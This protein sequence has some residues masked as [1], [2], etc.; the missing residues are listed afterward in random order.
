MNTY[1]KKELYQLIKE[2][3]TLF[4]FIQN[5]SLDG[6]SIWDLE[7]SQHE[8]FNPK[9]WT[10]LG[11]DI[12]NPDELQRKQNIIHYKDVLLATDLFIKHFEESNK[13]YEVV[14]RFIHK[15]GNI[16]FMRC[17]GLAI[18]N[19]A[20][21]ITKLLAAYTNVTEQYNF[22]PKIIEL[23]PLH[24][25][26]LNN[27][28]LFIIRTDMT[29]LYTYANEH[30][31]T[32]F[33]FDYD[34]L[35][36][37]NCMDTIY[38]A[39]HQICYEAVIKCVEQIGKSV[40]VKLRK[41]LAN[42]NL[43][44]TQWDFLCVA[45][46]EGNPFEIQCIGYEMEKEIRREKELQ[47]LK[48]ESE[49]FFNL[50]LDLLCIADTE[51]NFIKV[52]KVWEDLLGYSKE[53]LEKKKFTE[54]IH[55][56]DLAATY[57]AIATLSQQ[58]PLL[59][60][61]NRYRCQDGTYKFLEWT[62]QPD[63]NL[64]YAVAR[65]ITEQKNIE[66]KLK[67]SELRLNKAQGIAKIGSW[68]FDLISFNLTWSTEHYH[69]FELENMPADQLY[70]A[71]RSKIHLDDIPTLDSVVQ[72]AIDRGEGFI[73]EHRVLSND[74]SIKY[75]LGIGEVVKDEHGKT[76][77]LVGTVQDITEAKKIEIELLNTKQ[78]LEQTSEVAQIGGWELG[79]ATQKIYWSPITKKIH[80]VA[81]DFEPS[82]VQEG[83]DFYQGEYKELITNL[84][85][86]IIQTGVSFDSELK[87]VTAKANEI[88]V[89]VIGQAEME[90]G[91]CKRIYGT[92]QNI[93]KQKK[94]QIALQRAKKQAEIASFAKSDFLANMS[95]EIRTPLNGVIG[96]TD[97]LMKTKLEESQMQY[98][99]I[100]FQSANS[101]LDVV[102]DILDF[103]K[104][105]AGKLELSI[106]KSDLLLITSQVAD[107]V[108]FQA[109]KKDLEM[110]LNIATNIPRFIIAD[111]VRLRQI[112]VNLLSNA[113]KFTNDGEIELK[114]ELLQMLDNQ[115][116]LRFSIRDTGIGIEEKNRHKIFEA[117]IQEDI[118][119]TRK[120]G[121]TGLGLTISNKLLALMNSKLELISN[122]GKG[123]TFYFD[124]IFESMYGELVETQLEI[125]S[126]LIVDDN[127]NNRRIVKEMLALK[128]IS[129][130][131]ASNGIDAIEMIKNNNQYDVILMD[132]QMPYLDGLDTIRNI[133]RKLALSPE[134]Q[135][136]FLLYSS[137]DDEHIKSA[138]IE[139]GVAQKLVKPIHIQQLYNALALLNK[140]NK[141]T[142]KDKYFANL[143]TEQFQSAAI[144]TI[145]LVEDIAIN[146][147]LA[148]TIIKAVLPNVILIEAK[149]G[150]EA[151]EKYP[152]QHIDFIFMDIQM[153]EKNGYEATMEIREIEKT[154]GKD[155]QTTQT[156]IVAMTAG[157]VK[158]EKEKCLAIGMNDYLSK[159]IVKSS[160]ADILKQYLFDQKTKQVKQEITQKIP[161]HF[162]LEELKQTL[163]ND[164][165][166][167]NE[168]LGMSVPFF[169]TVIVE[170]RQ[171]ID[172]QDV[173]N[174]KRIAHKIKGT[175]LSC[176]FEILANL[177]IEIESYDNFANNK[178]E[179]LYE[180][181]RLEMELLQ[182][183][184]ISKNTSN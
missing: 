1:L 34:N 85:A 107:M 74:G 124:V 88:W 150:K 142:K 40:F 183:L 105:E 173:K 174:I 161:K 182:D 109:N 100:V 81:Q 27:Q 153:P 163:N 134:Q 5:I 129:S 181:I 135:P 41:P 22:Q 125:K 127:A 175:A 176:C 79:V 65:D 137:S 139:L 15:K 64:L 32:N 121:G 158:G 72:N 50:N 66:E 168:M 78:K 156:T 131:Q 69:I 92:F 46:N 38:E 16:I 160:V 91:V 33:G 68:E 55:P 73:Y 104:I 165:A 19:T 9:F 80:E 26:I 162:D 2:D 106:E 111:A 56:E 179:E 54:F 122:V 44:H 169:K 180:L 14:I 141:E 30:F 144:F 101:L 17:H 120:F 84:I 37:I 103:S 4:D 45:D 116:T 113:I 97:L 115:A 61:I 89:R 177:C 112:I 90:N 62:T 128:N 51:G 11:Y 99:N 145:M 95:H 60:F 39:D 155:T 10:T 70:E 87:I 146:M 157:T 136:I 119:I 126:V 98:M 20:G 167:V 35:M 7:N 110:L 71:Y 82:A 23:S 170:L 108:K 164:L 3:E 24:E 172:L 132:Y 6:L 138:C 36:G 43:A 148:R 149:N 133:R 143:E 166:T 123:S 53:E 29:G 76:V 25:S 12:L 118:S 77:A 93:D 13:N 117:F 178:I 42:G 94:M 130:D 147:L 184:I 18:K 67:N 52:N 140:E 31:C 48:N 159:P 96:F 28:F 171:A 59:H 47:A 8:W 152:Q 102:N 86:K 114:V 63:G 57:A 75:V 21:K 83:I 58:K 151:V 154:Q 49:N